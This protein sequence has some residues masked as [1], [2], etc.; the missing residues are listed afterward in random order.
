MLPYALHE[1][2]KRLLLIRHGQAGDQLIK[3]YIGQTNTRLT[4]HGQGQIQALAQCLAPVPIERIVCSDLIRCVQTAE[5]LAHAHGLALEP[6]ASLRE[7]SLGDWEGLPMAQIRA[8]D[9]ESFEHRGRDLANYRPPGGESFSDLQGR[10]LP[11][12]STLLAEATGPVAVVSHAGV[13]R[14]MLC[15]WLG[16][17]VDKVFSL[18]QDSGCL[19]IVQPDSQGG[20]RLVALNIVVKQNLNQ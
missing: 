3:R 4:S 2:T 5:I 7:I 10:V 9:P 14:V 11:V 12:F 13:N 16:L 20:I 1:Q 15:H 18:G 8:K 17:S 19:N 6:Y